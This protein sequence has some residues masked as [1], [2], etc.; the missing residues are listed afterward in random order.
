[1]LFIS[2]EATSNPVG[3]LPSVFLVYIDFTFSCWEVEISLR[4]AS[5]SMLGSYGE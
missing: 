1:M 3:D 4:S 2:Y 5:F